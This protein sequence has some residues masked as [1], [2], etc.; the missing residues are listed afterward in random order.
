[1]RFLLVLTLCGCQPVSGSGTVRVGGDV[2]AVRID[3][4]SGDV[5]VFTWDEPVV[6]VEHTDRG[7]AGAAWTTHRVR[8]GTLELE[9]GCRMLAPC[10]TDL[11]V[12]V[13]RGLPVDVSS[14]DGAV[15]VD[16]VTD[17]QV[18]LG[19]GRLTVNAPGGSI[20][21][22]VGW[23]DARVDLTRTPER[24]S[25]DLAGG[26][27]DVSLPSG[28]Y[29]LDVAAFGGEDVRGLEAGPGPL[30]HIGTRAGIARVRARIPDALP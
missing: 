30:V 1:M 13:P 20:R 10:R 27:V 15:T 29:D 12:Y 18:V 21:A 3:V 26:D 17:L 2:D 22:R 23:G 19:D 24:V 4:E 25:L 6:E 28:V 14:G 9:G 8:E 5:T 11:V 16:G 7:P